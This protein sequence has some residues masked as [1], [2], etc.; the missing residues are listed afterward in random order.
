M[1]KIIIGLLTVAVL[2]VLGYYTLL[3]T[4]EMSVLKRETLVKDLVK[5]DFSKIISVWKIAP[6]STLFIKE[7]DINQMNKGLEFFKE[8]RGQCK[9]EKEPI[10][11]SQD[12]I[13]NMKGKAST[14]FG[15]SIS[16]TYEATCEK[17]ATKGRVVFTPVAKYKYQ[18]SEFSMD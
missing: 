18:I 8:S 7:I 14:E 13:A 4:K 12:R 15:T 10:C 3:E 16:C 1:K 6:N 5:N 17:K 2:S 9:I 11:I